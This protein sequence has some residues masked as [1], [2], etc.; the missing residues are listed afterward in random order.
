MD[1]MS[2]FPLR[3][4]FFSRVASTLAWLSSP[5]G[6]AR[7]GLKSP[8]ITAVGPPFFVSRRSFRG[9]V[10]SL[11]AFL[12]A[13][14]A[15]AGCAQ[16]QTTLSV[17][18]GS[19]S[20]VQSVNVYLTSGGTLSSFVVNTEGIS[21]GDFA[22]SS[23]SCTVGKSYS[24][25]TVCKVSYTFTPQYAG[26][27]RGGIILENSSGNP[28][29][30]AYISGLGTGSQSVFYPVFP[31]DFTNSSPQIATITYDG[32]GDYAIDGAENIY[33]WNNYTGN[34][35]GEQI[36][37]A[38]RNYDG[39]Y[40]QNNIYS[41]TFDITGGD[42]A[43]D[44]IGNVYFANGDSI[45]KLTLTN[46][47]YSASTIANGTD[48]DEFGASIATDGQGNVYACALQ[49]GFDTI[50]KF[51]PNGT[52]GY[53]QTWVSPDP[54]ELQ[55][56]LPNGSLSIPGANQSGVSDMAIDS[57]GNVYVVASPNDFHEWIYNAANGTYSYS[58]VYSNIDYSDT[59]VI[60]EYEDMASI[61]PEAD[62]GF[63]M[64]D[65]AWIYQLVPNGSRY[66]PQ[67]LYF[68]MV[69]SD[70]GFGI[71]RQSSQGSLFFETLLG[72]PNNGP[73]TATFYRQ[74]TSPYETLN[75]GT[76]QSGTGPSATQSVQLTNIGSS[77]ATGG[78]AFDGHYSI[79]TPANDPNLNEN[80]FY[81]DLPPLVECGSTFSLAGQGYC[82]FGLAF[83]PASSDSGTEIG[84]LVF[85]DTNNNTLPTSEELELTG[86]AQHPL[87]TVTSLS[88][89]SGTFEGGTTFVITGTALGDVSSITFD[90]CYGTINANYTINSQTQITAASTLGCPSGIANITI[91]NPGGSTTAG[92][93][94]NPSA[95]AATSTLTIAA[96]SIVQ[97]ATT[98]LTATAKTG[99]GTPLAGDL[100]TFTS[101]NPAVAS[102]PSAWT[103]NSGVAT[104]T[105]TGLSP[106]STVFTAQ[107]GVTDFTESASLTVTDAGVAVGQSLTGQTAL[108]KFSASGTLAN[109]VAVAE[110]AVNTDF[111]ITANT[112]ASN[113]AYSSGATCT[114]TYTFSPKAPGL[115]LGAA[116]LENSSGGVL[117]TTYL[118]GIGVAPLAEV[119]PGITTTIASGLD[120]ASQV[121]TD[122]LG[123]V[124]YALYALGV[125]KISNGTTTL[126]ANT[127][128]V[129]LGIDGA[130]NLFYASG[131][132]VSELVNATGGPKTIATFTSPA[133]P[134][135]QMA[136]DGASNLYVA[137]GPAG[138]G[139]IAPGT[140]AVT[141]IAG[142]SGTS[143]ND[144][145]VDSAGDLFL[146]DS[147]LGTIY[148]VPNGSSSASLVASE[149]TGVDGIAV[150]AAGNLYAGKTDALVRLAAGS[151]AVTT[152][153]SGTTEGVWID[154]NGTLWGTAI[155]TLFEVNRTAGETLS[156]TS[157]T[158]VT[159][160]QSMTL[161]NDGNTPLQV[162]AMTLSSPFTAD[163]SS[164]CSASIS[165]T[166][167]SPIC[168]LVIDFD[169]TT[170]GTFNGTA[171]FTDNSLN[172][173]AATQSTPLRATGFSTQSITFPQPTTPVLPEATTTLTATA[174]SGLPVTY[175]ITSGPATI[176]GS[177][178]TYTGT[179]TVV[180][181]ANQ[182]GNTTYAPATPVSVTVVV[183]GMSEP[184]GTTSPTQSAIVTITKAGTLQSINAL[185]KGAANKDYKYVSGST[186][187]N[188]C[189][190][191]T[192]YA[193][194]A[195]CS[196][197]YSFA[198]M[199]PGLRTGAI[200]LTSAAGTVMGTQFLSGT[201][202]GAEAT[203]PG[204]TAIST[205]VT[206]AESP[207]SVAVDGNGDVFYVSY[208]V[209]NNQVVL[210]EIVAV[211]GVVSPSS[212]V[213]PV[214]GGFRSPRYVAIDGA[215]DLFVT[216]GTNNEADEENPGTVTEVTAVNGQ[217][218]LNS[219]LTIVCV[220]LLNPQGV[221]VDASGDV[222]V[223]DSENNV[224]KEVV[225]VNGVVSTSST[226]NVVSHGLSAPQG[227][228]V[229]S[230][231]DVFVAVPDYSGVMEIVAVNGLVNS[232]STIN[233]VGSGFW[234][235]Y[236][237]RV[238]AAGN[239]FV[240]DPGSMAP[241]TY[242]QHAALKE[243]V[244][245]NG[246][247]STSSTVLTLSTAF[248]AWGVAIDGEGHVFV[249]DE[250]TG[251]IQELD[252]TTAP[253]LAFGSA[254][255]GTV[256]AA[257]TTT[258][259][260]VGNS[261]LDIS[262]L[263]PSSV[264]FVVDAN[265]T[266]CGVG[267]P[268][269]ESGI[270]TIGADFT[271]VRSG[272][273]TGTI[274]IAD[275]APSSPQQVPLTGTGTT[276]TTAQTIT[277]PQPT[278][279]AANGSAPVTLTASASSGL[280]ITYSVVSGPATVSG[281]TLTY[282][283]PGTVVVEADQFGNATYAAASPV[284]RTISV[285]EVVSYAAPATN[286]NTTSATQTA[287]VNFTAGGTL[288]AID[289]LTE[290]AANLDFKP[291]TGGT[292]AVGT[293]YAAN[294]TCTVEYSFTPAAPG[295]RLGAVVLYSNA[296]TPVLMGTSYLGG[297]GIGPLALF[298]NGVQSSTV[299]GLGFATAV[300][301]DE[302]G[303]VFY[304][305]QTAETISEIA[306]GSSTPTVIVSGINIVTGLVV[307]GA[308]NLFYGAYGANKVY[309]LVGASGSP[310]FVA[311]VNSPD[312]DMA[313]DG[314]GNIYV[315][316]S[317]LVTKIAP[318][319][320]A[321]TTFGS[322]TGSVPGVTVDANGNLYFSDFN[323]N[324]IYKVAAGTT[325]PVAL[326][327]SGISGPR[328]LAV[329]AAGNLYVTNQTTANLV[330]LTAGTWAPTVIATGYEYDSLT[331]DQYGTLR[332]GAHTAV[333]SVA[334]STTTVA[335]P[336]TVLGN[337]AN[338]AVSLEN[339]GNAALT[340]SALGA[341]GTSFT[342]A[343]GTTTC[344]NTT[345]L[346]VAGVCNVGATFTPQSAGA[347]T[348]DINITDNSLNLAGS[349]QQA[350]LT[351]TGTA[352]TP[353]FGA[354]SFSPA[355]A[356]YGT[357]QVVTISDSLSYP[358]TPAPA[359]AVTFTLN[360][361]TYTATCT[362]TSS[363]LS[364]TAEVPSATVASL[365]IQ[366]YTVTAAYTA[367]TNY[368]AASGASGTFTVNKIGS[369]FGFLNFSPTS[370]EYY[371]TSQI[372]TITDVFNFGDPSLLPTGTVT[373]TLNGTP[374]TAT[375]TG[376][377]TPLSCT[378]TVPAAT[379][380][381][382]SPQPYAV[383]VAYTGD[384]YYS[385]ETGTSGTFEIQKSTPAF[386][387]MTFSPASSETYGTSQ[388]V[389]ISDSLIYSGA[390]SAPA[391]VVT[392]TLNNTTYTATCT[393]IVSP[394]SCSATVPAATIAALPI[395]SYTV[396]AFFA[397]DTNYVG[398]PGVSGTLTITRNTPSIG[399][400]SFSPASSET[401]GTYQAITISD[402]LSYTSTPAPTGTVT[403]TL[404]GNPY[405]ATCTGTSS[406]LTCTYTVSSPTIA[407]LTTQAYTVTVSYPG[408][409]NYFAA[410]GTGTFTI[411]QAT[412][413]FGNMTLS[414][415][416]SLA[417]G[418][419]QIITI[420]DSLF[421]S[422]A[423]AP[424]G[425]VTYTLNGVPYVATCT[426]TASPLTCTAAVPA[427][428]IAALSA[429][430][431]SITPSYTA[432]ANYNNATGSSGGLIINVST[433]VV[434]VTSTSMIY[435][436]S[437]TTLTATVTYVGVQPT[438]VVT[439]QVDSG[440]QVTA[441]CTAGTGSETCTANYVTSALAVGSHTITAQ[442]EGGGDYGL[443]SGTGT[444]T[445]NPASQT[446]TFGMLPNVTY[447]AA[448]IVLT[449]T[450]SSS[451]LVSYTVTG[452]AMLSGST[453]TI[454]G[455]GN[456]TVTAN[457]A[458]NADYSGATS[459]QQSFTVFKAPLTIT[460]T[461]ASID[462]GQSIPSFGY[463]P[464]GFVNGD[465]AAVLSGT[466]SENTTATSSSA[467]G[468]Y[469]ITIIQGTLAAAN[470]AFTFV[471]GTLTI[472]PTTLI[473]FSPAAGT[474]NLP[475]Q[476]SILDSES[477]ATIH[478][479]TDGTTPTISS[480]V[481]NSANP[482]NVSADTTIRAFAVLGGLKNSNKISA[483]YILKVAE[484]T[485]SLKSGTYLS[486]QQISISDTTS[487]AVIWYTTDDSTPVP[488]EGTAVQFNGTPI[489]INQT[490]TVKAVAAVTGWT[491]SN[492]APA[493]YTLKVAEP[494]FS[495]KSG[496]YLTP[497][498]VSISD[499]AA[500]AAIWY[501]T[502]DSM[503]VPGEGTAVQFTGTPI[504][505]NQDTTIRAV[506]ALTNFTTSNIATA[507]YKLE[508]AEP[509]F[510]IKSGTYLTAQSISIS[511]TASG[512]AI[513]YTTDDSTPVP[514]EGTAVQFTGTP[515]AISSTTTVK[516][517][518]ALTGWTTS[519]MATGA[520]TIP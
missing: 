65:S 495:I 251:E 491:T 309:E 404:N 401:Y 393:G 138:V 104:S 174:S 344:S 147:A 255:V 378:A 70:G 474:Y 361:V 395:S 224:V 131:E 287:T 509:A 452:P 69:Q 397:G 503:P 111:T 175:T 504:A 80:G 436:A 373:F 73:L 150:D 370:P 176:S 102:A 305:D 477:G 455:A 463:T 362:G 420:T 336:S 443:A 292:C 37:K 172:Y 473:T 214:A 54:S 492:E 157:D 105:V 275:N 149:L 510:S 26:L 30:E 381:A 388:I 161:E 113:T 35:G 197:T 253:T 112:C 368:N 434:S 459:V 96:S 78:I 11:F 425:A 354:M 484:P 466:P 85:Y 204:S 127:P 457:Q 284:Q 196:V 325:T 341:S 307:D 17:A 385:A 478:Y 194:N 202:T 116:V 340:I 480:A 82:A 261:P 290:G 221:A 317:D 48:Y 1:P 389:T 511:D 72:N 234:G 165:L 159:A 324:T 428:T 25:G 205:L 132:S 216:D 365:A 258:L 67:L 319:T 312:I 57:S 170:S 220:G 141:T 315:P 118:S 507:T 430:T 515:I 435:G 146:S 14:I 133:S 28:L 60:P 173:S 339:D 44:G 400:M 210:N 213:V 163:N 2:S 323:N 380:A 337:G 154:R 392:F 442:Q 471:N 55:I 160:Q 314:A 448:P 330:K 241:S 298:T 145:A 470:Y 328:G 110:G 520:Y 52:G 8:R 87:P 265:S 128:A 267:S 226:V 190:I 321:V 493:T 467:P 43:V 212:Q 329:D 122:G 40:T 90:S 151:Y 153:Y 374:Y 77:T 322:V 427:A 403:F 387:T 137:L 238:D 343:S 479:T 103:N 208:S 89:S 371:G 16:A 417:Y 390:G 144:V 396:T 345:A 252:M 347:L 386:G 383:T 192:A 351:G 79:E 407:A 184:V 264:D 191:G 155:Y 494:T 421:Y 335:F 429:T 334:R 498:Q 9:A 268:L 83:T 106:G 358:G 508:V 375:C 482:I 101:S 271:P 481:F 311:N 283:G 489:A 156:F 346:A 6:S 92:W 217:V 295:A 445:V 422:G 369:S 460:A 349:L 86:T 12:M 177:T 243:I 256:S 299:S 84:Q 193:A 468:S 303:D 168:S 461:N 179:G 254:T 297:T 51:T 167:A 488:G 207:F 296:S 486:P 313:V 10:C 306:A 500:G 68:N 171:T 41:G 279:P 142:P 301:V 439:I 458:G 229:D 94:Y 75:F 276:G 247:V 227:V 53:T 100:I 338:L 285:V 456:V 450:A 140:L 240:V 181:T 483:V 359:G 97:D 134:Q 125:E 88:P 249:A 274:N 294:Q 3:P 424:T 126:L 327:T 39:S 198:P 273:Q 413:T 353:T 516:A 259:E 414:P 250:S 74:G 399:V 245:T 64:Y 406:P 366:N 98:T 326:V 66:E 93:T 62:G 333:V 289:V 19:T 348:G 364:C 219:P 280:A 367:D 152:L 437:P 81:I 237:M 59:Q 166:A 49:T 438:G 440:G 107:D 158:G 293:A 18:L 183:G 209:V 464:S 454:T 506:A 398:A 143:F 300:A 282:T 200:S 502:D 115:R 91:T 453:L 410:S 308:G 33:F 34:A 233:F 465:T 185:T 318:G 225:A 187:S 13:L 32:S 408:D 304:G 108:V 178:A 356:T 244:A 36:I 499:T 426:G 235:P 272:A 281:S 123:N 433:P 350:T 195:T 416:S 513:W 46:N 490:T 316:G 441:T 451:L 22:F 222:F 505:V 201:G 248:L 379:I 215:G 332:S 278:T 394:L 27:R 203:F 291:V 444:L 124:Y 382:L 29:G 376:T 418:T 462:D 180:I 45:V 518:A 472:N 415:T 402:T 148:E 355:S 360:G 512:A 119:S 15:G 519:S 236:D 42:V 186:A 199:L 58:Y 206:G 239:V 286:V 5:G 4:S 211:N 320:F 95:S 357:G 242:G 231:G 24:A 182:S 331:M 223:A 263:G 469:P 269:A 485:Y 431:Y 514:G 188:A 501:T 517:V 71:L 139:K 61:V 411:T 50:A 114:V 391:G 496:T 447:G 99:S 63:L 117:G 377:A 120:G 257:Q 246:V 372:L 76:L 412:P 218:S 135:G 230:S 162:S 409:S 270:C 164:S 136:F 262:T 277:F 7:L 121:A 23:S 302:A 130:G 497:Q 384:A 266:T 405:T 129:G 419:S 21:N 475:Q 423:A 446:I 109:T 38:T 449:A 288:G 363:P 228:T 310:Q 31:V 260:N 476:V 189:T 20:A 47:G 342:Q 487:N 432:D 56:T 352:A 232:N 169:P